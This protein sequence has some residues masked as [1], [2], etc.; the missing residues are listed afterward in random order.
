MGR[1]CYRNWGEA[2][3]LQLGPHLCPKQGI[4]H[5]YAKMVFSW[6]GCRVQP[7]ASRNPDG[8]LEALRVVRGCEAG[9]LAVPPEARLFPGPRD[10]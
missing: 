3:W 9:K 10:L 2:L 4:L 6:Q 7:Q 5:E 1:A 8:L